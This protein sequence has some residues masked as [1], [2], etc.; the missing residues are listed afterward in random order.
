M[1]SLVSAMS[2]QVWPIDELGSVKHPLSDDA[3][4]NPRAKTLKDKFRKLIRA[5]VV[6]ESRS[7]FTRPRGPPLPVDLRLVV[8]DQQANLRVRLDH[9]PRSPALAWLNLPAS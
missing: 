6:D 4:N 9:Q 2:A 3:P 1:T 8:T 5:T 7:P